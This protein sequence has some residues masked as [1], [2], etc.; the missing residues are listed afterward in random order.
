MYVRRYRWSYGVVLFEIFSAGA[1]PYEHL[2]AADLL[3]FLVDGHR[4]ERPTLAPVDL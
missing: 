2:E 1:V 4:L 3:Q